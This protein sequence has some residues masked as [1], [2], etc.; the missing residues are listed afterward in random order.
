MKKVALVSALL[1]ASCR[2]APPEVF[3]GDDWAQAP[4]ESHGI[5][6]ARLG[7]ALDWLAAKTGANGI[8]ETVVVRHGVIVWKGA[9]VDHKVRGTFFAKLS[10]A[11]GF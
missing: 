7:E 2:T 4:P 3:P 10:A 11:A 9:K 8:T 1:L 5:D 6:P